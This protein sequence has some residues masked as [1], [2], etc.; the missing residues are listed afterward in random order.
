MKL[1]FRSVSAM[2]K[3]KVRKGKERGDSHYFRKGGQG[4]T[5]IQVA[6]SRD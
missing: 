1:N 5:F 2:K 3:T 4:G 6:V